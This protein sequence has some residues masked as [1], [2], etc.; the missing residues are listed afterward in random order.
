MPVNE[1]NILIVEDNP[2]DVMLLQRA[3][4]KSNIINPL[5]VV[6][7]GVEAVEYLSGTGKFTDRTANPLPVLILLDLKLPRKSGLEVLEWLRNQ[8]GI[9]RIPV[10]ILTSSNQNPDINRA[11]DLGANSYLVKPVDFNDLIKMVDS[12]HLFWMILNKNP[13]LGSDK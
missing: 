4:K 13:E 10:I 2:D 12:L 7:D 3:M 11:Y 6:V 5:H 9:K 1:Y 8:P